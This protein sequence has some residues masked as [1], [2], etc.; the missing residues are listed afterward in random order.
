MEVHMLV[1]TRKVGESIVIGDNIILRVVGL[2][3]TRVRVGIEAPRETHILREELAGDLLP[4]R[5]P[6]GSAG[7]SAA[8][9]ELAK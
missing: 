9:L 5:R 8:V 4:M 2:S 1:L 7:R 6:A 3:G